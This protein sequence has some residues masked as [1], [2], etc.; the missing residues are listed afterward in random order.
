MILGIFEL[1]CFDEFIKTWAEIG[2]RPAL[3]SLSGA[4]LL[5]SICVMS[6]AAAAALSITFVLSIGLATST[7]GSLISTPYGWTH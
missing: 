2:P 5:F 1:Q 3:R 4:C 7:A 6:A